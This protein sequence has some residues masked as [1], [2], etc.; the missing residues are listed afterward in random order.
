MR[1]YVILLLTLSLL[2]WTLAEDLYPDKYDYVDIDKIL[3]N[4]K[5]REQYYKCFMEVQPCVTADAQF[6]KE[7]ITE[8]F[9]TKCRLCTERQKEL[10]DK[11]ADWYNKNEPSKWQAFVEKSLNDAKKRANN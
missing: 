7:H 3:A 11:M 5:L 4:D 9:V 10:F 1:S 6:F 2:A 8:A